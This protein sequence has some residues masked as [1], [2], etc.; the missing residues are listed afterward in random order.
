V[1]DNQVRL[2]HPGLGRM[3]FLEGGRNDT[4]QA[5]GEGRQRSRPPFVLAIDGVLFRQFLSFVL[6]SDSPSAIPHVGAGADS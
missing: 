6:Y 2:W 5:C 3:S 4:N 1:F